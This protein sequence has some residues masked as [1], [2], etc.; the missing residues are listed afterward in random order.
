M[1]ID[2]FVWFV[3]EQ[4]YIKKWI[5]NFDIFVLICDV[6]YLQDINIII[7]SLSS[8]KPVIAQDNIGVEDIIK[9]NYNG[10]L[11]NINKSEILTQ[12]ILNLYKNRLVRKKISE[13]AEISSKINFN[14]SKTVVD[15]KNI[16]E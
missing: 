1:N 16:L 6:L 13:Q 3:G 8:K 10:I 15:F 14:I 4:K 9:N 7:N 5:N 2:N 12:E 11:A